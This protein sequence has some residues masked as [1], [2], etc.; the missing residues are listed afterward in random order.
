MRTKFNT[1]TIN[2]RILPAIISII[3]FFV[4]WYYIRGYLVLKGLEDYLLNIR[5]Y[6]EITLSIAAIYF[7]SLIIRQLSKYFERKY[8]LEANG[9]P[10]TYLM[11][12]KD[13]TFSKEYKDKYRQKIKVLFDINLLNE[14]EEK[15][16]Y[17]EAKKLLNEATKQV[18]LKIKD[19]Y[20]VKQHNIWYGF[21]RNLIGGTLISMALC[22]ANIFIGLFINKSLVIIGVSLLFV[23]FLKYSNL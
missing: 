23:Y 17:S 20:L 3:P 10:T 14:E 13:N 12:Y 4:M 19:G 8:F 5:F 18:I 21:Y 6:G 22:I 11:T 1:Y 16:K 7:C 9:F 2:A 15:V